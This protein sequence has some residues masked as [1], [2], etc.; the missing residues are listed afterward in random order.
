[1]G[2]Y[3]AYWFDK[4]AYKPVQILALP[5]IDLYNLRQVI[6]TMI[7]SFNVCKMG[8]MPKIFRSNLIMSDIY[9]SNCFMNI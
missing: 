2:Y 9:Y 1:M 4:Q 3:R 6:E 8:T 5:F 7:L